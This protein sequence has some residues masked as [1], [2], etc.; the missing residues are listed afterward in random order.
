MFLAR[1]V[2]AGTCVVGVRSCVV[3]GLPSLRPPL[4]VAVRFSSAVAGAYPAASD[5][6]DPSLR[7]QV[8]KQTG[9]FYFNASPYKTGSSASE[10]DQSVFLAKLREYHSRTHHR[11]GGV[12]DATFENQRRLALSAWHRAIIRYP[13]FCIAATPEDHPITV[14]VGN[15]RCI[16]VFTD[17]SALNQYLATHNVSPATY[18]IMQ[19]NGNVLTASLQTTTPLFDTVI[20]NPSSSSSSPETSN[21]TLGHLTTDDFS[22]IGIQATSLLLTDLIRHR[23]LQDPVLSKIIV[24]VFFAPG[25]MV[26][27]SGNTDNAMFV[28]VF[29]SDSHRDA[30]LYQLKDRPEKYQ[31][32]QIPFQTFQSNLPSLPGNTNGF[33]M[34]RVPDD[35]AWLLGPDYPTEHRDFLFR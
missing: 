23:R 8:L 11:D 25:G 22:V 4:R 28:R 29:V 2:R 6:L 18:K 12:T 3:S 10:Q 17:P 16:P 35:W 5:G 30:T 32:V 27:I 24:S 15:K 13:S 33:S 21:A 1:L 19:V 7:L 31:I 26:Y 9:A 14:P 20:F 34:D